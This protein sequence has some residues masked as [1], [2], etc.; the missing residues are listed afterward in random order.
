MVKKHFFNI[1]LIIV[2]QKF[3][4]EIKGQEKYE[5]KDKEII[6]K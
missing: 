5:I 4:P 1:F 3:L 2:K 6:R